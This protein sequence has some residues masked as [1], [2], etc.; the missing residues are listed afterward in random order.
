[1]TNLTIS[2]LTLFNCSQ[3]RPSTS[4]GNVSEFH[5][6]PFLVGLYIWRCRDVVI[7]QENVHINETNGVG[8]VL[9]ETGGRVSINSSVFH[10]NGIP[11]SATGTLQYGGGGVNV[12]SGIS[13]S[14]MQQPIAAY[15]RVETLIRTYP[16]ATYIWLLHSSPTSAQDGLDPLQLAL[17]MFSY[18]QLPQKT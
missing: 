11:E 8:L 3:S 12:D 15:T 2:D 13:R 1:M 5:T 4:I 6:V 14:R 16:S 17:V 18:H 7:D 9:Y 10:H